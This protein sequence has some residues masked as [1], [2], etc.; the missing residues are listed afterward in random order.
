MAKWTRGIILERIVSLSESGQDLT[1][2]AALRDHTAL[3]RAAVRHFGSW[4]R[5]AEDA[6][7]ETAARSS[8]RRWSRELIVEEIWRHALEGA[9]LSWTAMRR[10]DAALVSA[11]RKPEH[12]GSWR[13]ALESADVPARSACRHR[14]WDA[15]SILAGVS[16]VCERGGERKA[17]DAARID[18]ALLAAARRRFGSWRAAVEMAVRGAPEGPGR[19]R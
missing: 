3:F 6:G 7:L 12:F 9:D 8:R 4:R 16:Q 10:T 18:P 13:R 14:T 1:Y 17:A 5:A 11:A 19:R 2:S 15:A